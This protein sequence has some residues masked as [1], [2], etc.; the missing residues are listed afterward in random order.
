[1]SPDNARSWLA[2][3]AT[4]AQT[5]VTVFL[6][7]VVIAPFWEKGTETLRLLLLAVAVVGS[8]IKGTLALTYLLRLTV[9]ALRFKARGAEFELDTKAM[10]PEG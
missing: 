2:N 5:G 9:E 8:E 10:P 3:L 1:M 7:L 6:V 4:L